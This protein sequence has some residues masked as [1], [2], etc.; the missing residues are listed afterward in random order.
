[1]LHPFSD[2]AYDV[3]E[4]I[5]EIPEK[6]CRVMINWLTSNTSWSVERLRA[7]FARWEYNAK[8]DASLDCWLR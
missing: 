5:P 4:Y 1:M 8:R 7:V 2:I 3:Q 6:H